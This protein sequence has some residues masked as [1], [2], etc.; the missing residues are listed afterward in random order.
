MAVIDLTDLKLRF[1][2]Q[3]SYRF[4]GPAIPSNGAAILLIDR[5]G[6]RWQFRV[7]TPPMRYEPDGRQLRVDLEL[8]VR[9]GGLI[10]IPQPG[11]PYGAPGSPVVSADTASGK[12]VPVSGAAANYAFRKGQ[13]ISLVVGGQRYADLITAQAIANGSGVATLSIANLIRA[14]LSEDDV[15]E[16]AAKAEGAITDLRF[17]GISTDGLCTFSFTLTEAA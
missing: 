15:V 17:S 12:S 8:A 11:F 4:G 2:G 14:P 7:E 16:V 5:M 3:E 10:R 6:S 13:W 1:Q 9:Q